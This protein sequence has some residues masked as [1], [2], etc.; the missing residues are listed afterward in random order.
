[1]NY[2]TTTRCFSLSY[3]VMFIVSARS[4]RWFRYPPILWFVSHANPRTMKR[5]PFTFTIYTFYYYELSCKKISHDSIIFS[6]R[7]STLLNSINFVYILLMALITINH[8][9]VARHF[10]HRLIFF[11]N[12]NYDRI[13]AHHLFR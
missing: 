8:Y 1:M 11:Y 12:F 2:V 9:L 4:S 3:I 13:L 5:G 6:I 10:L 7:Y